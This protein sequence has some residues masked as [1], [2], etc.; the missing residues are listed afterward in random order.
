MTWCPT[1]L[2]IR[3]RASKC[4][5]ISIKDIVSI[6]FSVVQ[7]VENAKPASKG[8]NRTNS[9]RNEDKQDSLWYFEKYLAKQFKTSY[10]R[11][12]SL[13]KNNNI[14]EVFC[15]KVC[16]SSAGPFCP[17]LCAQMAPFHNGGGSRALKWDWSDYTNRSDGF[18]QMIS[19]NCASYQ[20]ATLLLAN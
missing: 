2:R 8:L 10:H 7:D 5:T 14:F 18:S 9:H 15:L 19:C 20:A 17:D 6:F 13:R 4:L 16:F 12:R 3:N 11:L 1:F